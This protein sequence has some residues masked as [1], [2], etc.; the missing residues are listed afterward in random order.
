ML[1]RSALFAAVSAVSL[2]A[3][4]VQAAEPA[5]EVEELVVTGSRTEGRT[6]L[7]TLA[8]VDVISTEALTRHGNTQMAPALAAVAPSMTFP[9]PS[10]TDGTDSLRPATP[11]GLNSPP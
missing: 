8:P 2:L 7:E 10:T 3:G 6:R 5:G 4:A 9:R 11:P 1:Y